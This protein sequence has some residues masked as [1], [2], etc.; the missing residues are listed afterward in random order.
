MT[1]YGAPPSVDIGLYDLL[2]DYLVH[3]DL[4]PRDRKS[5]V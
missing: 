5:V 1:L 2:G 3:G 4:A